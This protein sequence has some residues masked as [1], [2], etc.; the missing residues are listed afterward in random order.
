MNQQRRDFLKK[1]A[2][3]ATAVSFSPWFFLR[4]QERCVSENHPL[5]SFINQKSGERPVYSWLN[6]EDLYYHEGSIPEKWASAPEF[7]ALLGKNHTFN[8][9][10]R[11]IRHSPNILAYSEGDSLYLTGEQ[12]A[13]EWFSDEKN[14]ILHKNR[15]CIWQKRSNCR[16]KD[17]IVLPTFQICLLQHPV[18]KLSVQASSQ[19]EWQFSIALK[20]RAGLP[21]IVSEWQKGS[22]NLTFEIAKT[23]Q[24][25]G[26]TLHYAELHF[27]LC[28]WTEKPEKNAEIQ[29][30][31]Y[32][33]TQMA[34][35]PC[36]PVIVQQNQEIPLSAILADKTGKPISSRSLLV[37][38][39]E[40]T[41][42]LQFRNGLYAG[43]FE[44]LPVG[45][46]EAVFSA[47]GLAPVKQIV[48][49]TDG[50]FCTFDKSQN[51]IYK[52]NTPISPLT[53][54]FQGIV[55]VREV[56]TENEKIINTQEEYQQWKETDKHY[57]YWESLTEKE[58]AYRFKYLQMCGWNVLHICQHWSSWIRFD[59]GGNISPFATEQL[60]LY[61]RTAEKYGLRVM[62]ALTHY[63]YYDN[64]VWKTYKETGYQEKLHWQ[65]P[66]TNPA[67]EKLFEQ[68]LSD[69][70]MF[71]KY[72]TNIL[73]VSASGEGD[74]NEA[75]G[76]L[77][78]QHIIQHFK[79]QAP[80]HLVI[81]EPIWY[82]FER[83]LPATQIEGWQMQDI[84]GSRT[85]GLGK[86]FAPELEIGVYFRLNQMFPN[87]NM[88][89]GSFPAPEIYSRF[90]YPSDSDLHRSWIGTRMHRLNLR[91]SL[92]IGLTR[93]PAL[94]M[95]WEEYL[96]E[97]ERIV[98][99]EL[100]KIIKFHLPI[101]PTTVAV[102]I[103]PEHQTF[104]LKELTDIEE[105]FTQKQ[106]MNYRYIT[107]PEEARPDEFLLDIR[108]KFQWAGFQSEGGIMPDSFRDRIPM[109]VSNG[110]AVSFAENDEHLWA[111]C[112]NVRGYK[113]HEALY[114]RFH[115]NPLP[116]NLEIRF[117]ASLEG[118]KFL[119]FSLNQKQIFLEG[120]VGKT[121]VRC[122][123]STDDFVLVVIK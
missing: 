14:N 108:E 115:R 61:I 25:K 71:L 42:V 65:N 102:C 110:Y 4:A 106:I 91:D 26:Y 55:Y 29:F 50:I 33:P 105:Q 68:Y 9:S 16:A 85:Y 77:R 54:S 60:A 56:G 13:S 43:R 15:I 72:E 7:V 34:L 92:Y 1:V 49:V 17:G 87:I 120:V 8:K 104:R 62:I 58:L 114:A 101:Y 116:E 3:S 98:M 117:K 83:G 86:T 19:T 53:G 81:G 57:H 67:F 99:H 28:V 22:Q 12:R 6:C 32:F 36:L 39:Q 51:I 82:Y 66:Q 38:I 70:G 95:T 23:L 94:L 119:L 100:K 97:D 79:K 27:A 35:V 63:P 69:I 10:F 73:A 78:A 112:Y 31:A 123:Q 89:E 118:R 74:H 46:Y 93:K 30:V 59:A 44:S 45:N 47:E 24:K 18:L 113:K 96:T 5:F 52:A 64:Q 84:L 88:L 111:Y 11:W 37:T 122:E 109:F 80:Y 41:Q 76:L 107:S 121:P 48:R 20:G 2:F 40:K 75:T 21:L 103:V 90:Y